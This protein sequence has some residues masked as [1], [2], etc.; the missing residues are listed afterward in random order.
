M[1]IVITLF[2]SFLMAISFLVVYM[3][4]EAFTD[5]VV[6]HE[7]AFSTFPKSFDKVNVFFISDIHRRQISESIIE[8]VTGKVDVVII[9]GDLA[10]KGVPLERIKENIMK[11]KTLGPVIFVWGNNDYELDGPLLDAMLLNL[12][13]K[14]LVNSSVLFE[15][16]EA[17]RLYILGV[18]DLSTCREDLD[19]ALSETEENSFKILVSHNPE[20]KRKIHGEHGISLLLSGHTHGGQIHLLGFSFYEKGNLHRDQKMTMLISNGYGTTGIPLR[21]GA[22]AETHLLTIQHQPE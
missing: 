18:D 3:Y 8:Q 16:G 9:G 22:K 11:L 10:E 7:L 13:V 20:I 2:I 15:S 19:A 5:R 1:E 21:L 6:Y 4:K 14:T 12:G 17:D